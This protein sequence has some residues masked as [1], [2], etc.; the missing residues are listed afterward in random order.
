MELN[1][2]ASGIVVSGLGMTQW[3]VKVQQ[4]CL[5]RDTKKTDMH[6]GGGSWSISRIQVYVGTGGMVKKQ[7]L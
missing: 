5:L 4:D 1:F 6:S 3:V 7:R 2:D